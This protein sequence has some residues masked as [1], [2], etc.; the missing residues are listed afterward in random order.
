MLTAT[1][2][3]KFEP[4]RAGCGQWEQVGAEDVL[5]GWEVD[6]LAEDGALEGAVFSRKEGYNSRE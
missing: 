4:D 3:T 6:C 1:V 5:A 2:G